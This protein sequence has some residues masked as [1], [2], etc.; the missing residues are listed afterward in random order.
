MFQRV[1]PITPV[2]R[3]PDDDRILACASEAHAEYIVTGDEDLLVLKRYSAIRIVKPRISKAFS[4]NRR[5][6]RPMGS[7]GVTCTAEGIEA[8]SILHEPRNENKSKIKKP[9]PARVIDNLFLV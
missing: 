7:G 6:Q 1:K 9:A 4:R 8:E 5:E 3:D 2:C